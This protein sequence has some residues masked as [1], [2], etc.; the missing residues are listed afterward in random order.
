MAIIQKSGIIVWIY[1]VFAGG[2]DLWT[3]GIQPWSGGIFRVEY[4][5]NALQG[6]FGLVLGILLTKIF[7]K[8]K[9]M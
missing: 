1:A 8:H 3:T 2:T 4:S 7:E 6:A 5:M 9:I